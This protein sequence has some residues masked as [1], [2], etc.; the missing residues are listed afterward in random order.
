MHDYDTEVIYLRGNHD[1]I[2]D[3]LLPFSIG[4]FSIHKEFFLE[5]GGKRFWVTHGDVYDVVCRDLKWLAKLGDRGYMFL[6]WINKHYNYRRIRKRK[7]YFS[8]SQFVKSKVKSAVS[9]IFDF[10]KTLVQWQN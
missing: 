6:L 7:P 8:L 5:S 9:Y 3:S 1:D 2:I 4:K 10:Q